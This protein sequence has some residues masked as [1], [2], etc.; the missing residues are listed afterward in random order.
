MKPLLKIIPVLIPVSAFFFSGTI[1]G[2]EKKTADTVM[3]NEKQ[4]GEVV[5]TAL[6]IKRQEKKLGYSV[7]QLKSEEISTNK[8]INI[9][10]ALAGKVAG[11]DIGESANGLAGSKR[12]NLRG[13]STISPTGTNSPLWV[14]DG[15]PVN[16][17]NFGRNNDAGGGIDFGDGLSMINPDDIESISVLKGNAA[18]AL[19]GSRAS[20]GVI[21]ITTK[22]GKK[23]DKGFRVELSSTLNFSRIKDLT[24]W[25]YE[26]GQGRDGKRP[27]SQQEALVTGYLSW[28][29]KM[30][31]ALAPQFDGVLRPYAP[32]KNNIKN[33]YSD[34][35]LYSNTLSI[36]RAQDHYNFRFSLGQ[37]D[38]Q[39][40]IDSGLYKKRNASLNAGLKFGIFE[41]DV[42][43]M[44]VN[45]P[46]KNRQ[47]IGGNVRNANYTMT[48]IPTSV[49]VFDMQPG[50]K[51]DGTE[52]V[53][54]ESSI[55]NPYYVINK[56]YEEDSKNR[57][58]NAV[59]LRARPTENIFAQVKVMQDYFTFR[60]MNYQPQGMNWQPFGG[61]YT[62]R[63]NEFHEL[64]YEFTAGYDKKFGEKFGT[65]FV[66]GAN[67]RVSTS[68]AVNLYGTPFVVPDV[69]TYNNTL[70]RTTSTSL[71]ETQTNSLFG[72]A[73]L[74]YDESL[75]LTLTGRNDWFST[76][77]MN[78]NNYFYPSAS[79]SYV[80]TDGLKIKSEILRFGKLRASFAQVS[81]GADP[82]SLDLS[83]GIDDVNYNGQVLQS[84][85]TTTIPNK[86]LKPLISSEYEFGGEFQLFKNFLHLD[87]AYFNKKIRNDIVA[88]NVSNASSYNKAIQNTGNI[89]NSGLEI[90][91][92][93]RP[94]TKGVKWNSTFTFS[95]NW[96]NVLDLGFGVNS[97]QI[98]SAKNDAVT[99][100]VEKGLP[101]GV[102]K[103]AAYKRNEN[104]SIIFD[105]NGFP[106]IGDRAAVLGVAFHDKVVGWLN[107]FNYKNLSLRILID[108]KFGGKMYSQT[109]RWAYA[110]GKHKATL[111]GRENGIVGV[112]VKEDGTVN[113]IVVTP[114]KLQNYYSVMAS[115]HENFIYDAS[116]IKLRELSL[117]YTLPSSILANTPVSKA[118]VSLTARNLFYLMNKMENVSPESS[119]TSSNAQGL[120]NSGYPEFIT[121]GINLNLSF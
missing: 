64:N 86:N 73:E 119:V 94:L 4:I 102:I 9:Q 35:V 47:N 3:A 109:N 106:M 116:F 20:N 23:S 29:E 113:D 14:I 98:G 44:Y 77:P 67:K 76:L 69:N 80:F 84:I 24:D 91:A 33:F 38:S 63:W 57:V 18:A 40:F 87:V 55:T 74:S 65:S 30:D 48:A 60:R 11:L 21:I 95:K 32:V 105:K 90:M 39:D 42:N 53:I 110:N 45:E 93:L 7:T 120:E 72:M 51:P 16:S 59:A 41:L 118:T 70:N 99:V 111:E 68:N 108:G 1:T 121:Y 19:Y 17:S 5:V 37:T 112:G 97:L 79:L 52:L 43:S 27:A 36:S 107:E 75:F 101:Y 25:Q 56:V 88:I 49:N 46:V 62:E 115:I 26:Y 114:D 100:N 66:L 28:G 78:N 117:G 81:G 82:Y 96:N 31:G 2:Q 15:V 6:G 61:E 12:T 104:G 50:F 83:Y 10:S 58:V 85:A 8:T 92:T 89:D 34:A 13:I 103:G 54:T 71:S 22:S